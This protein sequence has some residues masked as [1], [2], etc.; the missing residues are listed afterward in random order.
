MISVIATK[1]NDKYSIVKALAEI[2]IM[3]LALL[4]ANKWENVTVDVIQM[5]NVGWKNY[6][7]DDN[8]GDNDDDG[9]DGDNDDDD[10]DDGDNDDDDERW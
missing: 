1:N 9:N 4:S 7:D 3:I 10:N 5:W 2:N 6:Y 8:D